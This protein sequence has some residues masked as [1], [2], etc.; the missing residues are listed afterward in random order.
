MERQRFTGGARV[1]AVE[2]EA[3]TLGIKLPEVTRVGADVEDVAVLPAGHIR[4]SVAVA[5]SSSRLDPHFGFGIP[6]KGV[7]VFLD[8][9]DA[10][11]LLDGGLAAFDLVPAVGAQRA[12]SLDGLGQWSWPARGSKS[13]G[14]CFR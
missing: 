10:Q 9:G 2:R 11:N 13:A 4:K 8:L 12:H 6:H 3:V 7:H 1:L 14:A 5:G